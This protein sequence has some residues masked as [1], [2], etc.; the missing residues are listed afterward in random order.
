MIGIARIILVG[1]NCLLST[2]S[3]ISLTLKEVLQRE[4]FN[5]KLALVF[6]LL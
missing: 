5:L 6:F 2:L 4:L 1:V 3:L